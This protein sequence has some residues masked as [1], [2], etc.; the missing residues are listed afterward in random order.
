MD[1]EVTL[2]ES[3]RRDAGW[4]IVNFGYN[5]PNSPYVRLGVKLSISPVRLRSCF[6]SWH[7]DKLFGRSKVLIEDHLRQYQY[8]SLSAN[9]IEDAFGRAA[10][11][12]ANLAVGTWFKIVKVGL[13]ELTIGDVVTHE[14]A[15]IPMRALCAAEHVH[16]RRT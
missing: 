13:H 2:A 6:D 15:E 3:L 9:A 16:L 7:K 4:E 1:A 5:G 14:T 10:V 11:R 8:I 12:S